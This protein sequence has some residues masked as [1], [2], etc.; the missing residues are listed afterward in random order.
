MAAVDENATRDDEK[1]PDATTMRPMALH[2]RRRT[3]WPSGPVVRRAVKLS[4]VSLVAQGRQIGKRQEELTLVASQ[5]YVKLAFNDAAFDCKLGY[6]CPF[7]WLMLWPFLDMLGLRRSS[8][9]YSTMALKETLSRISTGSGK[10]SNGRRGLAA[11]MSTGSLTHGLVLPVYEPLY[12]LHL[13]KLAILDGNEGLGL[14]LVCSYL[15]L[16]ACL[17]TDVARTGGRKRRPSRRASLSLSHDGSAGHVAPPPRDRL[18]ERLMLYVFLLAMANHMESLCLMLAEC[19]FPFDFSQPILCDAESWSDAVA[20]SK[21]ASS[22]ASASIIPTST[23]STRFSGIRARVDAGDGWGKN[24]SLGKGHHCEEAHHVFPSFLHVAVSLGLETLVAYMLAKRAVDPDVTWNGVRPL[25]LAA[26]W[27]GLGHMSVCKLLLDYGAD[28]LP[29]VPPSLVY[30]LA[31]LKTLYF[32]TMFVSSK[33]TS[34]RA[35]ASESSSTFRT[36]SSNGSASKGSLCKDSSSAVSSRHQASPSMP[37]ASSLVSSDLSGTESSSLALATLFEDLGVQ[38]SSNGASSRGGVSSPAASRKSSPPSILL[39]P[40]LLAAF[41]GSYGIVQLL[42][43]ALLRLASQE[44]HPDLSLQSSRYRALN[45][46][47]VAAIQSPGHLH[48]AAA[49]PFGALLPTHANL[50]F[51]SSSATSLKGQGSPQ[52]QFPP[53]SSSINGPSESFDSSYPITDPNPNPSSVPHDPVFMDD[54]NNSNDK[55]QPHLDHPD[56]PRSR[57]TRS[58]F[59][60]SLSWLFPK[61]SAH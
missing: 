21:E 23:A 20:C 8:D 22:C 51:S 11:L 61:K 9:L 32:N 27:N 52:G 1:L 6:A 36:S 26:A 2:R 59:S 60:Q 50:S 58:V 49:V 53:L 40:F 16:P 54:N 28:P 48:A 33:D 17:Q 39:D 56:K 57:N 43:T 41:V 55:R 46:A 25:H 29:L 44:P 4:K 18:F 47:T 13:L 30:H 14:K 35:L 15:S 34:I 12:C 19:G 7:L 10:P 5:R 45:A 38:G 3:R 42:Q 37:L 24:D 31:G